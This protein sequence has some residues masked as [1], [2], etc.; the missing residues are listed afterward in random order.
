VKALL[1][2]VLC[3]NAAGMLHAGFW[4]RDRPSADSLD[5]GIAILAGRFE[6]PEPAFYEAR[7]ARILPELDRLPAEPGSPEHARKILDALPLFD[8]AA[9][10]LARLGR[11]D[12][13]LALLDL[14]LMRI[15]QV[16]EQ[17]RVLARTH[18]LRALSN[19]A[20]GL[21][22]RFRAADAPARADLEQARRALAR[23]IE[24]DRY[25]ADAPFL[26][27]LIDFHLQPP[28]WGSGLIVQPNLLGLPDSEQELA[29]GPGTLAR[30]QLHGAIVFLSRMI[31]H[32]GA[33]QDVDLTYALSLAYWLEGEVEES[34]TAWLRVDELLGQG[35]ESVIT[36]PP[37]GLSRRMSSHLGVIQELRMQQQAFQ[38]AR[39]AAEQWV[40]RRNSFAAERMLAGDHPDEN[41]AFWAGFALHPAPLP[42]EATETGEDQPLATRF[43]LGG[44]AAL[45]LLMALMG[46]ATFFLGRRHAPAPTIDEL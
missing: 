38:E 43:I 31:V 14:K 45:A 1:L 17:G 34:I 13:C 15:S 9:V 35:I 18:E 27:K 37:A 12:E 44:M 19:R 46:L 26:L 22:L 28:E 23:V 36:N 21:Y 39:H 24:L 7:L 8:D 33:W 29:R 2:I 11:F 20:M 32:G 6:R 25:H 42:G 30:L 4:D 40:K 3:A 16:R 5:A 41:P 10:S